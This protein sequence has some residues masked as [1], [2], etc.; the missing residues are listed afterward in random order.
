MG[1]SFKKE[2]FMN[3]L[4]GIDPA[5][6]EHKSVDANGVRLHYVQG[7][8]GPLL[9]LWHGFLETW[10]C[11]RKVMPELAKKYTVIAA[12]MRGYGDSEKT[13]SG[14]D[15]LT[16]AQDFRALIRQ[17]GIGGKVTIIAHDMGAPPALLYSGEYAEEVKALVYLDNP[18]LTTKNMEELHS[19]NSPLAKKG[20]LWWWGFG[21]ASDMPERLLV[22]K[23]REFLTW[24]YNRTYDKGASIEETAVAEY[25]RSFNGVSGIR[26]AFGVYRD[27]YTSIEQT[28]KY[29]DKKIKVPVMALGGAI[30]LGSKVKPM[31]EGVALNVEGGIVPD[32]GHFIADE[33]PEFLLKKLS[34]FLD[35]VNTRN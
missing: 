23:E 3:E 10:Y 33:R 20:G 35:T 30:G 12:D 25:L 16:L 9:L 8:N 4:K 19:F 5:I 29:L 27:V 21:L 22:G 1:T 11:W 2:R 31:V 28:E 26:G 14:Y 17:T 6:F 15:T 7:G 24:F 18:V 34:E 32:C 13:E